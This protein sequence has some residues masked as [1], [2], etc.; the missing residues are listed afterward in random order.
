MALPAFAH[1]PLTGSGQERVAGV[2]SALLLLGFWLMYCRGSL[3]VRPALTKA[4]TFHLTF[5]LC[6]LT[7]LGPLDDL[8]QTSTAAHM[9]QH[10][11][12]IVVIAPLWVLSQPLP[13]VSA[14]GARSV[15]LLWQAALRLAR[16]PMFAAYLHGAV[17]W[18]WHMPFFYMLAVDNPWWHGLEHAF[19]LLTAGIFWWAVMRSSADNFPAAVMALL[20]TLMH[21][22]FLGA[23]LSFSKAPVY[24]ESR[25]VA[26]QQLAGLIMW[27]AG[28][29]PYLLGLGWML[30]R[31]YL[32]QPA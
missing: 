24:G 4:L 10:M 18:I 5:L 31:W 1:N 12:M 22:G 28:S 29:G 14:G 23:L 19:F 20:F 26:D 16:Y 3:R 11:L 21:T 13:Q 2:L 8:A 17:I 27:V 32:R 25:G 9:A 30:R 15:S 7:I 6:V